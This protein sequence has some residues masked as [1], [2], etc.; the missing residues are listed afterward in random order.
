MLEAGDPICFVASDSSVFSFRG[1]GLAIEDAEMSFPT[2]RHS[3]R[4]TRITNC[5]ENGDTLEKAQKMAAR[6]SARTTKLNDRRNDQVTLDEWNG[7]QSDGKDSASC[8][9]GRWYTPG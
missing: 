2:R 1:I 9:V 6:E 5:L 7:S 8:P 3:I 4:A